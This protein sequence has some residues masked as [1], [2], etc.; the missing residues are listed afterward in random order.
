VQV[1]LALS[2]F[3]VDAIEND[4]AA[5]G[6]LQSTKQQLDTIDRSVGAGFGAFSTFA[7]GMEVI[8]FEEGCP[9]HRECQVVNS[10][11]LGRASVYVKT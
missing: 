1:D 2:G 5:K 8:F 7:V 4:L 3:E 6:Y 10:C 9:M 11:S